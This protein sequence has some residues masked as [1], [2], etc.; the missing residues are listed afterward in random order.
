LKNIT[1]K[2]L[3]QITHKLLKKI[4]WLFEEYHSKASDDVA[5]TYIFL[6][7]YA[8]YLPNKIKMQS[9][10]NELNKSNLNLPN[11]L[12]LSKYIDI[13]TNIQNIDNIDV[14]K[15]EEIYI[16]FRNDIFR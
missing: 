3:F 8:E 16:E 1:T 5:I 13:C 2:S 11:E 7:F 12:E 4:E 15:D 10:L 9:L 6:K 14:M